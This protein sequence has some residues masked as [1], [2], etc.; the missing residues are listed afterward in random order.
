MAQIIVVPSIM[1]RC[2]KLIT[3]S[4]SRDEISKVIDGIETLYDMRLFNPPAKF[5][6]LFTKLVE[7]Q[8]ELIKEKTP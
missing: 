6:A 8:V 2:A 3:V 7:K 4:R 1:S 5:W